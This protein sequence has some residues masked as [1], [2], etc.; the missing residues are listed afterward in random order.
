[1]NNETTSL[2][3]IVRFTDAASFELR[4]LVEAVAESGELKASQRVREILNG[5]AARATAQVKLF[6]KLNRKYSEAVEAAMR[7]TPDNGAQFV[8]DPVAT[9]TN[10]A[11]E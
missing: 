11:A 3:E 1:M 5:I 8:A 10:L 7:G 6:D 2:L 9:L 4:Q